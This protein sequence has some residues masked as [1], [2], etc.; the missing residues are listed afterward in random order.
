SWLSKSNLRFVE[1]Q[2]R[3]AVVESVA[4]GT[5]VCMGDVGSSGTNIKLGKTKLFR[6]LNQLANQYASCLKEI[7]EEVIT[8]Q[9]ARSVAGV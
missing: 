1:P 7:N 5:S 3:P 2:F 8:K 9:I 4:R 6:I